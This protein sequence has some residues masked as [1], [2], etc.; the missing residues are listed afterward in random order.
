MSVSLDG[1]VEWN[2]RLARGDAA[3]EVARLKAQ[4]GFEMGVGGPTM[5]STLMRLGLIDEYRL[6]VHPVILG[7]GTPFFPTLRDRIGLRRLEIRPSAP[8]WSACATRRS[9]ERTRLSEL[10]PRLARSLSER[11]AWRPHVCLQHLL[12]HC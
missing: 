12:T 9:D 2:G 11:A 7:A 5:A 10:D 4:P 1:F 6:F 8:G 3:Q